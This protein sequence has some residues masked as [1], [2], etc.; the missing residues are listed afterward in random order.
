MEGGSRKVKVEVV[1][2]RRKVDS[3][4]TVMKRPKII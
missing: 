1:I 4:Y 2:M 3:R